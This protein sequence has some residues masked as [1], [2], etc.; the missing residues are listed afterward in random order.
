MRLGGEL[1]LF[2]AEGFL[3]QSQLAAIR[4]LQPCIAG[5]S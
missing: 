5:T 1:A 3:D 4:S 2:A